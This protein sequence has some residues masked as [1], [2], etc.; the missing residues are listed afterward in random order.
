M[1]SE[2][3]NGTSAPPTLRLPSHIVQL[4]GVRGIAILAVMLV[5]SADRLSTP[6][7][8]SAFKYG[9]VGVDLFF[10]LSG[11]LITGILLQAR[12]GERYFRNFYVRRMLR[13]WP[14]YF[15]VLAVA[16]GVVPTILS[17]VGIPAQENDGRPFVVYALFLQNLWHSSVPMTST[18]AVTW[19][20]AIEEQFYF[21]W[22]AI[23]LFFSP[24]TLKRLL[25]AV[26]IVSPIVRSLALHNGVPELVVYVSTIFRLDGLAVGCLLA[27][28]IHEQLLTARQLKRAS[29]AAVLVGGTLAIFLTPAGIAEPTNPFA[30]TALAVVFG[31]F[32]GLSLSEFTGTGWLGKF[33]ANGALGYVGTVSYCVYLI[34]LPIFLFVARLL[35]SLRGLLP[36]AIFGDFIFILVAFGLSFGV[37]TL[38]WY[39]F[40][41]P[42][43]RL[44]SKFASSTEKPKPIRVFSSTKPSVQMAE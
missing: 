14:L 41:R 17:H 43:L 42:I 9:W 44:K 1:T 28:F 22:P 25:L 23:V 8:R 20:L 33:L 5:H 12:G 10:V 16:F 38:S 34:H 31:G 24:R 15:V 21:I 18:L 30:F 3:Q 36:W 11:F 32:V 35:K 7:M 37:A 29:I 6:I 27:V 40:E 26:L 19:S 4:D 39:F 13:V 2:T